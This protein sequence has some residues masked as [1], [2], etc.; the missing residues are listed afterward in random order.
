M[1]PDAWLKEGFALHQQGKLAEAES[2]YTQVLRQLPTS[3]DALHFLGVLTLQ[4]GRAL[5]GVE[6]IGKAIAINAN[7]APAHINLGNGFQAL[8]RLE[9][10]L[11]SY[12]RAIALEPNLVEAHILRGNVLEDLERPEEALASYDTAIALKPAFAEAHILRGTALRKLRRL[13]E[14]LA[15]Y[16]RA[17]ALKPGLAVAYND[18]GN[19]LQEL[20]RSEEA[21]ASCE[22]AIALLP[23]FAEAH[24]NRGNSLQSLK[25]LDEALASYDRAIAL[26]PDFAEAFRNR[27]NA[28]HAAKRLPEAMADFDRAIALKPDFAQTYV[29]RGDVLQYLKRYEQAAR[30]Y[31]QA[32]E[33]EPEHPFTKGKFLHQ[34]MLMCDW[35]N[36][37]FLVGEISRDVAAGKMSAEPFGWQGL[38]GSPRSLQTC[39]ELYNGKNFPAN[40]DPARRSRRG[41][42]AKIRV[43]Y[44]SGEFREQAIL[45]LL[46]GVLE[47]HDRASFEIFAFDNGWDDL[48]E[49]RKRIAGSVQRIIDIRGLS[50][51]QA[52]AAIDEMRIDVLVNLNGYTGEERTSVFARRAAPIQV[53]YLGYPGTLGAS[54]MDYIIADPYVIPAADRKYYSEKVAYLPNCYQPN[55]RKKEI[56]ARIFT[57]AQYGL[58]ERGFVF[59]CFNNNF[60]IL[61][62]IF[63]IWMRILKQVDGSVLWLIEDNATASSNLRKE[64]EARGVRAERLI[65]ANRVPHLSDHLARHRCADLFIDTLPFNAHTTASDALWAGLP[66]LTCLG[67]TFAGRVAASLL[68]AIHLPELITTTLEGYEQL[69]IELATDSDKL[70]RIKQKLTDNRLTTPL[71]DTRLCTRHIEAAYR[72]MCER[73]RAGLAPDHIVIPNV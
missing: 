65:F 47:H 37:D 10:A 55:D 46:I 49:T 4:T 24:Y 33:I 12:D 59:C 20:K 54:Y 16:D 44:L 34:K 13:E 15:S 53:N 11:A 21:L 41:D 58:P 72:A 31:A 63:D 40:V 18:R 22:W 1:D 17:T 64:A 14:A 51:S 36:F 35:E 39:A 2:I 19:T 57:R 73:H 25:R 6:L 56:N 50:D 5:R 32:L 48:S 29:D 28:L 60:K 62:D 67:G 23:D 70:A 27:G 38:T 69:A 7:F 45:F 68:S 9:E 26:K 8:Q 71:F 3:F 30:A 61:P 66:V 52:V 43:G 42:H